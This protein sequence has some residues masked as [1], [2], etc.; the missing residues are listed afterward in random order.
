MARISQVS[1]STEAAAKKWGGAVSRALLAEEKVAV[2]Y[3]APS[4]WTHQSEDW[5]F[6]GVGW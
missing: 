6:R 5:V 2:P 1:E 3:V 4:Y